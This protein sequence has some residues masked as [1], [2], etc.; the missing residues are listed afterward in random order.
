MKSDDS[1]ECDTKTISALK[2]CQEKV[3]YNGR[4]DW[5]GQIITHKKKNKISIR[6]D[7]RNITSGS[8]NKYLLLKINEKL[9]YNQIMR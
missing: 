8:V 6:V 7:N 2:V 5:S 9:I 3:E 4:Q 1:K